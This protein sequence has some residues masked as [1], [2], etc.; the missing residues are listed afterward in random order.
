MRRNWYIVILCFLLSHTT[1]ARVQ[2]PKHWTLLNWQKLK[3]GMTE[4]QVIRQ[5]GEPIDRKES[6]KAKIWCYQEAREYLKCIERRF[7]IKN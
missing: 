1:F 3:Q 5:L 2:T 7:N 4:Q 6:R